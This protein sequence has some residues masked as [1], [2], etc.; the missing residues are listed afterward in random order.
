MKSFF[1]SIMVKLMEKVLILEN[2]YYRLA[3]RE[4]TGV[5]EYGF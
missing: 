5:L 4:E 2:K 3:N 1:I